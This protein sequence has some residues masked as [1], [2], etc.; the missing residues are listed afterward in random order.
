MRLPRGTLIDFALLAAI[1]AIIAAILSLTGCG[2]TTDRTTKT[3][4]QETTIAGPMVLDT[5]FGQF[6]VH[7]VKVQHQRTQDEVEKTERTINTPDPMPL[8]AAVAG[9]TPWGAIIGAVI[10]VGTTAFG[11]KKAVEAGTVRRQRDELI[12]GV[13][14]SKKDL[15]P[16]HWGKLRSHLEA[17][18]SRDT[19]TVV[20]N[21]V[22]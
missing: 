19:K 4:E 9:G 20:K 7:P 22:G 5:P 17:E 10:A 15:P 6:T 14:R 2:S 16:K 8:V 1:L 11:A 12:D 13:E 18:Q 21:R 3:V